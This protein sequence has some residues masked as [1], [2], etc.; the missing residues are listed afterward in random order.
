[1]GKTTKP[2]VLRRLLTA[3]AAIGAD[4]MPEAHRA[5]TRRQHTYDAVPEHVVAKLIARA[6]AKRERKAARNRATLKAVQS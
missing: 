2:G 5:L 4:V 6:E 1:M 3:M